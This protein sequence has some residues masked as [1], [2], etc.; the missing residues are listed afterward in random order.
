MERLE[1]RSRRVRRGH[2][3]RDAGRRV[4][5]R[6]AQ[7]RL[8]RAALQASP[9][10]RRAAV[11][12]ALLALGPAGSVA[13]AQSGAPP[14]ASPEIT[15]AEIRHVV[16]VLAHD[17]LGGRR[18]GTPGADRAASWIA[19]RFAALGLE[20]PGPWTA[21][22]AGA[23]PGASAQDG[24]ASTPG[25]DGGGSAYLQVFPLPEHRRSPHGTVLPEGHP[26]V[27]GDGAA[28]AAPALPSGHPP[29]S[30]SGRGP[31]ARGANVVGIVRGT[32]PALAAQAV[33]V[34]AHYDHLGM[35]GE[36]SLAAGG[37]AIHNGADDNASGVAGLLE[38]AARFAADPPART[39]VF[40]AFGAEELG[41][42]GSLRYVADPAW[43][44]DRTVAMLNLDMI[45]RL[46]ERL[47]VLG[48][49]TSAAW[50][51][52]LEEA[53]A[54][55]RAAG[56]APPEVGVV[57]DGYGPSDHASFYGRGV[58]VLAFFTGAH[59]DYHRPSDDADLIRPEG[60]ERVVEIV[61]EVVASVAGGAEVAWAEAP[62][63]QPRPMP[64]RVGLG[65]MPDY[66]FA[67]PGL[68]IAGVRPG[69]PADRAGLRTGDVMRSLDGREIADV[70]GYTAILSG[71]EAGREVELVYEREGERRTVAV[72]PEER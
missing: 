20:P 32:D 47:T 14:E 57:P 72:T 65:T 35:G 13:S 3:G 2:G 11:A 55:V 1:W 24:S 10:L 43:P 4:G 15:A 63:T 40:A 64:F 46:R 38:L 68:R 5:G 39:L 49:G 33:V 62:V 12:A 8:A 51:G 41:N 26:P 6:R 71:L 45:G 21:E 9:P 31:A 19:G 18:S 36:G 59:E 54:R 16:E 27:P 17:S 56:G 7:L 34:G 69:S 44:L 37:P 70:Y 53:A 30:E 25:G 48:T 29:V 61:A 58:P 23:L 67:G 28:G 42:V 66:G 50:P 22:A 60:T 52:L